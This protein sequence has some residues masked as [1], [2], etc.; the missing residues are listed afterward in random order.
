MAM[1]AVPGIAPNVPSF[2]SVCD[3]NGVCMYITHVG[4]DH[5]HHLT[6]GVP[7]FDTLARALRLGHR[8][9]N[10]FDGRAALKDL[11]RAVVMGWEREQRHAFAGD[12]DLMPLYVD[13]FLDRI[14]ND[15]PCVELSIAMAPD[16]SATTF[17]NNSWAEPQL[18]AD[19][20][21]YYKPKAAA[22]IASNYT[23]CLEMSRAYG[24]GPAHAEKYMRL[25]F[26]NGTTTAHELTHAF[27][28][29]LAGGC[30]APGSETPTS[31]T[32]A[33]LK[34]DDAHRGEA[35]RWLENR[36]FGGGLSYFIPASEAQDYFGREY[37]LQDGK[38]YRI[39]PDVIED[40]VLRLDTSPIPFPFR[41]TGN[42]LWRSELV[43]M[44]QMHLP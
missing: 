21:A 5:R 2:W 11:G 42:G 12:V 29:Y 28:G 14:K 16:T 43:A 25:L 30:V 32:F 26:Q 39:N 31:V 10:T 3:L 8:I 44:N 17:R 23:K 41:C 13:H 9:L 15:F 20:L 1:A 35:G 40:I 19:N 34:A 24:H 38:Y 18:G 6:P 36:L 33:E 7:E 37:L 27:V 4:I 22:Y